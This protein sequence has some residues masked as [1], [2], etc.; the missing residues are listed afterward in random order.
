MWFAP[1]D[2]K[3][4]LD[5]SVASCSACESSLLPWLAW[6]VKP[7]FC[8]PCSKRKPAKITRALDKALP[9]KER[10]F[11][12][13]FQDFNFDVKNFKSSV[14]T[15]RFRLSRNYSL[16]S[17]SISKCAYHPSG[18][19]PTY[20]GNAKR[21]LH[22][23]KSPFNQTRRSNLLS[24]LIRIR[25]ATLQ[26]LPMTSYPSTELDPFSRTTWWPASSDEVV[27]QFK[28]DLK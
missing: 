4:R 18:Q 22:H 21:K 20:A 7:A 15:I 12:K 26:N 10:I 3:A 13:S 14:F 16:E 25:R 11:R 28:T 23:T 1:R 17:A 6:R 5:G 19:Y 24:G 2:G 27:D 8:R 9:F